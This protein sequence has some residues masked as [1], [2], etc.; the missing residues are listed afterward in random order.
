[1]LE[2]L[3]MDEV[4]IK[5]VTYILGGEP[6]ISEG[7]LYLASCIDNTILRFDMEEYEYEW[8]VGRWEEMML[9]GVKKVDGGRV[10][11]ILQS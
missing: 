5:L 11:F 8:I 3:L 9:D 2:S 4:I 10:W 6:M 1:M 7:T